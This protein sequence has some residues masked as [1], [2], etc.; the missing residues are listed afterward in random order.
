MDYHM[1]TM[2]DG[3]R[4]IFHDKGGAVASFSKGDM[5]DFLLACLKVS[6]ARDTNASLY[7]MAKGEYVVGDVS[8]M[9]GR[10]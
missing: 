4:I 2:R 5:G 1:R 3:S 9:A 8:Q 6:M 7:D 10:G